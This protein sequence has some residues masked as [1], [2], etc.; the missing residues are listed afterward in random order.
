MIKNNMTQG[1]AGGRGRQKRKDIQKGGDSKCLPISVM[2]FNKIRLRRDTL[3]SLRHSQTYTLYS[4]ISQVTACEVG[5][6]WAFSWLILPSASKT[7][8]CLVCQFKFNSAIVSYPHPSLTLSPFPTMKGAHQCRCIKGE[9]NM[10]MGMKRKRGNGRQKWGWFIKI[11][12]YT[13]LSY[14][15]ARASTHGEEC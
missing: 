10:G 3:K 7:W 5:K 4:N 1:T 9:N 13:R 12:G 8:F 15:T 2:T 11:I 14:S 6:W